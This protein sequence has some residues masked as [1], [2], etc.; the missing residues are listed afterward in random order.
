MAA[1]GVIIVVVGILI[2]VE[3]LKGGLNTT[4][5]ASSSTSTSPANTGNAPSAVGLQNGQTWSSL[6]Q[7]QGIT[8]AAHDKFLGIINR[9]SNGLAN[10]ICYAPG[11]DASKC[12]SY[13]K[14]GDT[15]GAFGPFQF[16]N[17]TWNGLG[18]APSAPSSPLGLN[19]AA[20][21]PVAAVECAA[22]SFRQSGFSAWGG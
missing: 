11:A 4:A 8:G 12:T 10:A 17:S 1:V 22:K 14:P 16:L 5:S 9:E 15:Q 6:L 7:A 18:C 13:P 19:R 2:A 3:A 20:L 21:D